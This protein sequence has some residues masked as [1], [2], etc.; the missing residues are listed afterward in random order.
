MDM[1]DF[2]SQ[3][4]PPQQLTP[5]PRLLKLTPLPRRA[6]LPPSNVPPRLVVPSD[7]IQQ[8]EDHRALHD[9]VARLEAHLKRCVLPARIV[10]RRRRRWL[11]LTPSTV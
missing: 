7:G 10:L 9:K 3:L 8:T 2:E 1:A 11:A 5:L 4:A 6:S